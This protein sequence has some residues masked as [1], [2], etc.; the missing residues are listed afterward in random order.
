MDLPAELRLDIFEYLDFKSL[1]RIAETHSDHRDL[2]ERVFR[3]GSQSLGIRGEVLKISKT[4][5]KLNVRDD[6]KDILYFMEYFGHCVAKLV[7]EYD[8]R[9][10]R[11][12]S[13][14]LN[15]QISEYVAEFITEIDLTLNFE[16]VN[17]T[18]RGLTLPFPNVKWVTLQIG[19]TLCD[20]FW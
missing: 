13:A 17:D 16:K 8:Y 19:E 15:K 12:T 20:N 14:L 11:T 10:D 7:M 1:L 5:H 6:M 18:M 2:V 9:M 4:P 3:S